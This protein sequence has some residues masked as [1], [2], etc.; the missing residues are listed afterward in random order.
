MLSR[1]DPQ[2]T[3]NF[4]QEQMNGKNE[5]RTRGDDWKQEYGLMYAWAFSS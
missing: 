1:R 4:F 5:G 3:F 2:S